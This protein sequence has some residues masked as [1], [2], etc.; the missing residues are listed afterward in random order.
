MTTLLWTVVRV[1]NRQSYLFVDLANL[2]IRAEDQV[3]HSTSRSPN[4]LLH[5]SDHTDIWDVL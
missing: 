1:L 2:F 3:H 5:G 4:D